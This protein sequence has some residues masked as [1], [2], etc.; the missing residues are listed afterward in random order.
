MGP[1]PFSLSQAMPLLKRPPKEGG[2]G[3]GGGGD[4][5]DGDPF[6][7]HPE[8][9][10]R[11]RATLE[12]LVGLTAFGR[13]KKPKGNDG[14]GDG[15]GGRIRGQRRSSDDFGV[16]S[17][18]P[19]WRKGSVDNIGE[20]L[21]SKRGSVLRMALGGKG[22]RDGGEK[23][24]TAAAERGDGEA[25]AD[26]DGDGDGWRS[27]RSGRC[28]EPLSGEGGVGWGALG[29]GPWGMGSWGHWDMGALGTLDWDGVIGT[30]GRWV[31]SLGYG[32]IGLGHWVMGSLG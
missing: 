6:A 15:D 23:G 16:L 10:Y 19:G 12:R 30:W 7:P 29:M 4:E 21:G 31:G 9:R 27:E 22:R 18:L 13:P 24:A 8:S 5:E 3:G 28:N 2:G 20:K 25:A 26:G 14:D 32:V 11:R 17:R 1:P